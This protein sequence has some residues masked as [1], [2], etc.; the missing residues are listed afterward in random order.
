M[1]E[2]DWQDASAR[3]RGDRR[4]DLR[5]LSARLLVA[6]ACCQSHDGADFVMG[7]MG[8]FPN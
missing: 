8:T 2:P 4:F 7:T 3:S 1:P 6:V 5:T